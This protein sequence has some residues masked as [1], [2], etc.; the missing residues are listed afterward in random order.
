MSKIIEARAA[1]GDAFGEFESATEA[2]AT[3]TPESLG[4]AEERCATAER[5]VERRKRVVSNLEEIATARAAADVLVETEARSDVKVGREEATYRPNGD[6]SFFRDLALGGRDADAMQRLQRH[7]AETETRNVSSVS[8]GFIPPVYLSNLWISTARPGRVWAD[9][10]TKAPLP[11]VGT[12]FTIPKLSSGGTVA[13]Q[14]DGASVSQT[15]VTTSTLTVPVRTIAGQQSIS[16]QLLERSLPQFDQVVFDD[17]VRAYDAELDRQLLN[18][19]S[20]SNEHV[21]LSTIS[22]INTTTYTSS[23]PTGAELLP[24]IYDAIQK[25]A[26]NRYIYPTHIIMHPRRA[27]AIA[28]ASSA[29]VPLLQQG[30]LFR[31]FGEQDHGAIGTI[32]G[33]PVL[34]DPNITTTSGT[35]T[36]QDE[37]YVVYVPDMVLMEGDLRTRVLDAPL[38][39]TLEVR[40]QVFS[41]SAAALGRYPAGVT[42]ISGTGLVTPTF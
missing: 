15:D 29:N 9:A 4:D 19:A 32:A 20:G 7:K 25:V 24:K 39:S 35:G 21:G 10:L 33:L 27:A 12:S 23:T 34:V 13:S 3:A 6:H 41:Y 42:K 1:L 14:T 16:M 22:G 28:A 5:E 17:L 31:A 36:N 30:G 26:S 37:I 11:D 2:V 38:S 8:N 40:L 18:G